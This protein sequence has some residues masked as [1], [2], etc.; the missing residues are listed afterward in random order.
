MATLGTIRNALKTTIEDNISTLR[1]YDTMPDQTEGHCLLVMPDTADFAKAFGRGTDEWLF[2]L[3]VIIP[4]Q[5]TTVVQDNLDEYVSGSGTK[6][7]RQVIWNNATLGGVVDDA[8][9]KGMRGFGGQFQMAKVPHVGAILDLQVI[10]SG[11]S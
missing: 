11:T 4:W 6:S 3:Y 1:V 9:V 2:N 7:V 5:E 8:F 10:T